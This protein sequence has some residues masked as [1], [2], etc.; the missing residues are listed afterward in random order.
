MHDDG[1]WL[2]DLGA[3]AWVRV[4]TPAGAPRPDARLGHAAVAMGDGGGGGRRLWL[5]GGLVA[6]RAGALD[7]D[8]ALGASWQFALPARLDETDCGTADGRRCSA[9][10]ACDLRTRRC[11]CDPPWDGAACDAAQRPPAEADAPRRALRALLWLCG[12]LAVGAALGWVQRHRSLE[13]AARTRALELKRERARM[14][15]PPQRAAAPLGH[16]G[17]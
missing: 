16:D 3:R 12:A 2:F 11:V 9:H 14:G 5:Y 6:G 4:H 7:R 13:E 17:A 15:V 8:G 10:G 1:L